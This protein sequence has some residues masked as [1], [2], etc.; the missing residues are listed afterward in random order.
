MVSHS[1]RAHALLSASGAH[2]W[3]NC[4]PSARLEDRFPASEGKYAAEGTLAHELAELT[5]RQRLGRITKRTYN[6][7]VRKL[8][9]SA[10]WGEDMPG[11]VDDYINEV[12]SRLSGNGEVLIEERVDFS[13][14]VPEG[15]GTI[16]ATV[17]ET[18]SPDE[19]ETL[20]V[21]DLK[22][23]KGLAV[24]AENNPQLMLYAVGLMRKLDIIYNI[25]SIRLVIVQPR[26]ESVS[27]WELT[28]AALQKWCDEVATPAAA[29]A[30]EGGG[31][32]ATGSWC[33]FCRAA[34]VCR[35]AA[36]G[37]LELARHEFCD[38]QLLDDTELLRIYGMREPFKEWMS[39][40]E[41]HV[42]AQALGGKTWEG[43]KLVEG[44]SIRRWADEVGAEKYL[45]A[46]GIGED[47]YKV[48]KLVGI[49]AAE[50]LLG[51]G[52]AAELEKLVVKP[53][54]APTLVPEGDKREALNS[55]SEFL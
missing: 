52:K 50:K 10:L 44:R 41:S 13:H 23:G 27:E 25:Q 2:R 43:Y 53:A 38:P 28:P 3:L 54:G 39:A 40:V 14:V 33:R 37:N 5:L 35:A 24:S 16:D 51:K 12:L 8:K 9:G 15:F 21:V 46:Q 26:L 30:F 45:A 6:A 1:S 19:P 18:F 36:E 32:Q 31:E 29:K 34:A 20:H 17:V 4:P 42:L 55:A 48:S 49:P 47:K 11:Y 7:E 22:Y